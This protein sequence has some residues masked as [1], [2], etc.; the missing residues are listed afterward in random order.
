MDEAR[1]PSSFRDPNGALFSQDGVLYR[2]VS[3]DYAPHYDR[4]IESG[5]YEDLVERE[6]LI[7]HQEVEGPTS[8]TYKV[9][10]PEYVPFISYPYEWSY[11]QLKDAALATLRIQ[12]RALGRG[13][14]LK[15]ASAYNIQFVRGKPLLIDTLSFE[16]YQEGQPWVAYRQFCQHFLAPLALMC[17][18][19]VRLG[20]LLRTYIDGV[21]LDLA[22]HLLP[23]W[24]RLHPALS[25]HIHLHA[26]AQARHANKTLPQKSV[27]RRMS[28]SALQGLV[29]SLR[30]A[31]EALEWRCSSS[32][33]ADYYA[34]NS[35][36]PIA[37]RH[38][39]ELIAECLTQITPG[40]VWDLGAN[41]GLFSRT[42]AEL[43]FPTVAFEADPVC[44]DLHY[45]ACVERGEKLVLPLVTDLTNPSPGQG[46]A[47]RER[48]SLTERGPADVVI[49][50]ALIHHLAIGNNVPLR[51]IAEFL[52]EIGK[53][54]LIEFVPKTDP[55]AQRLLASREDIFPD[56]HERGFREAFGRWFEIVQSLPIKDSERIIYHM[57]RR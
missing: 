55:Q 57:R 56:Y 3:P 23:W 15:D 28:P 27:A 50:L 49:A 9:L 41:L 37:L 22:A 45:R 30:S 16:V 40:I 48:Q 10:Q 13:L 6:L 19:D 7:P 32:A 52:A 43:G 8:N 47:H 20:A 14:S 33:W 51:M 1:L 17:Y 2:R 31:I 12:R 5:L 11:H 35:Y 24:T 18:Q 53:T 34:D 44:A 54:L 26:K 21:P 29:D 46:W 39:Q 42:A 38:K 25:L 4:L 36:T